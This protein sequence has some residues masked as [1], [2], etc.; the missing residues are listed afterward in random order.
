MFPLSILKSSEKFSWFG[1]Y[2]R[3]YSFLVPEFSRSIL[4][5]CVPEKIL[6]V[7]INVGDA[8]VCD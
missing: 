8:N 5:F 2:D 6:P 7:N 1:T 3:K 4:I